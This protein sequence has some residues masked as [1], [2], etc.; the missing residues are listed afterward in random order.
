MVFIVPGETVVNDGEIQKMKGCVIKFRNCAL[1]SRITF[2]YYF[3]PVLKFA[4]VIQ[5]LKNPK[6]FLKNLK[7]CL[8]KSDN[9]FLN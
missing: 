9:L 1:C 6:I 3:Q 7:M 4:G 8:S 5:N 2:V